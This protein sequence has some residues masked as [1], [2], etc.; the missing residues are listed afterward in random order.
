MTEVQ[1]IFKHNPLISSPGIIVYQGINIPPN[2][3]IKAEVAGQ[4]RTMT[5]ITP[6]GILR[7]VI[8]PWYG[9]VA[10]Q[11]IRGVLK[12]NPQNKNRYYAIHYLV[13]VSFSLNRWK[14]YSPE[15]KDYKR[16]F[17]NICE[18][19][20]KYDWEVIDNKIEKDLNRKAVS[21]VLG[22]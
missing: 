5:F 18:I 15:M 1:R 14:V 2:C 11:G 10:Q 9:G 17:E 6:Y 13:N 21:K 16:W 8:N 3:D 4:K 20:S 7:I 12:V 19:L 22:E